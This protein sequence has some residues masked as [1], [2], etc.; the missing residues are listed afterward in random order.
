[1]K[2]SAPEGLWPVASVHVTRRHAMPWR[3]GADGSHSILEVP[4]VSLS[5]VATDPWECCDGRLDGGRLTQAR[6]RSQLGGRHIR[7]DRRAVGIASPCPLFTNT[8]LGGGFH[9]HPSPTCRRAAPRPW[10]IRRRLVLP[11]RVDRWSLT[12]LQRRLVKPAGLREA[13]SLHSRVSDRR[14]ERRARDAHRVLAHPQ[15]RHGRAHPLHD[16]GRRRIRSTAAPQS[17]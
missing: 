14:A 7:L 5:I 3:H 1:M 8:P 2:L 6:G 10:A 12:S 13:R 9:L 16:S 17:C 15:G 11:R 4:R